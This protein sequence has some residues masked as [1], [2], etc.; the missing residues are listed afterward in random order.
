[1]KTTDSY[2]DVRQNA[3]HMGRFV[4]DYLNRN[5]DLDYGFS[6]RGRKRG[7][8][9]L[10][11]IPILGYYRHGV[12]GLDS[13]YGSQYEDG[14]RGHS[15]TNKTHLQLSTAKKTTFGGTVVTH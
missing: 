10:C 6:F 14:K 12:G 2:R 13:E 5:A 8:N 9:N 3:T 4:R 11:P 7:W 1:M 15:D